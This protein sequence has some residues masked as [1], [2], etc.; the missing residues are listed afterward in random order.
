DI[1]GVVLNIA[2]AAAVGAAARAIEA[3]VRKHAP[4]ADIEGYAVQPMVTRKQAQELILGMSR[5]PIFGPAI[6]FGAGGVAVEVMDD[7]AIA[8]PPLDDV[9]ASDLIGQTRIGRLLAGF[10]DR[11]P[12]NRQ[13]IIAALNGLSQ[14]IVDFPCL[15]AVDINP[16]LADAEGVIALDARIEIEPG[17]VEEAGPNPALAIRPYPSGWD[18]AFA[19]GGTHYHIRPIKPADIALYPEFLARISP[20]DLRLRFLSPRKSFSDQMLKRFTQLDYDRN[21]AFVAL[22]TATGA[23]A[24]ISRLSCDPDRS[25]AEYA[26]LVRTDLQGHGLGWELLRQIVAYAKA[27]GIGWIEGIVLSENRTMLTMCR[28]FGFSIAHLPDEPGLVEARLQLH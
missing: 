28:E 23:L 5:D 16:L 13:A 2:D 15:V 22:E 14:M 24:G 7:T 3:G 19:G 9:L 10:R 11:K 20:D 1:D 21:M 27:D 6:L 25:V 18:K 4:Q 26:L 12:T 17:R 8:L